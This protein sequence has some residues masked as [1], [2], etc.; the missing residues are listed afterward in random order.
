MK[1]TIFVK[2]LYNAVDNKSV[3][4]LSDFLSDNVC[5]RIA[6]HA[7]INGKEAVLKA[8]QIFF[9]HHQHVASY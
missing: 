9:Q 4:D 5:F 3:Q 6:N 1:K 8:N 7:P 2:N